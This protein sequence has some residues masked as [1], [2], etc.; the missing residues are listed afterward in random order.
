M[1]TPTPRASSGTEEEFDLAFAAALGGQRIHI[2]LFFSDVLVRPHSIDPHQ[3]FMVRTF[4][5]KAH[6]LGVLYHDYSDHE[7]LRSKFRL[8][9]NETYRS[10]RL[11]DPGANHAIQEDDSPALAQVVRLSDMTMKSNEDSPQRAPQG[12][13]DYLIPLAPYRRKR[14]ELAWTLE[15]S[16][17]YFRFGIKYFN[18][19]ER[20][21]STGSIQ[22]PG[23]NIVM[24]VGKNRD[25][26]CWFKTLYRAGYRLG[27]DRFIDDIANRTLANFKLEISVSD[28]LRFSMDGKQL[29]EMF[30]PIDEYPILALLGWGDEHEFCCEVRGLTLQVWHERNANS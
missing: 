20:L 25:S 29:Y 30:F 11:A 7:E 1:G 21:F 3:F 26:A 12:A 8:S 16:S 6:R 22:T 14:L 28:I 13:Y 4:R 15:T 9:L 18:S 19:Q 27:S 10:L 24:H 17:Q 5:E 23:Q 2:I